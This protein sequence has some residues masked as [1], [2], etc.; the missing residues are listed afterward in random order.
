VTLLLPIHKPLS[1]LLVVLSGALL[2]AAAQAQPAAVPTT[3]PT[4]DGIRL[5]W[6]GVYKLGCW[7]PLEVEISGGSEPIVGQVEVTVPDSDGVPTTVSTLDHRPVGVDPGYTSVAR[8]FVRIGQSKSSI[9][10]RFVSEGQVLCERTFRSGL[11]EASGV[12]RGGIAATGQVWLLYGPQLGL[13]EIAQAASTGGALT[14]TRVAR[15]ERAADLPTRWF[16]YEG[17]ETVLLTTSN[18]ALYRPLTQ[19]SEPIKA[20]LRWVELGGRLVVFC[21]SEAPELLTS[22]GPLAPLVPGHFDGEMLPL[23]KSLPLETYSGA[24]QSIRGRLNVRV[25]RLIDVQGEVL[26]KAGSENAELPLVVRA[27]RGLGELIFVGLDFD[28]PPWNSWPG[29]TSFFRKL[30]DL[31]VGDAVD[32]QQS[33]SGMLA[34]QNEDLSSH[35]RS[36]LDERFS[37]VQPISFAL[38]ALL[39]VAYIGLIGPGDFFFVKRV[40]KRMELTWVT[41]P[42]IVAA[43]AG[44]AYAYAQS[45]KGDQLRVNQVE[46]VDVDTQGGLVRGTVW[47]HFFTPRVEQ[48]NLTLAPQFPGQQLVEDSRCL[49]SWLGLPGFALGGMQ[50]FATEA[51]DWETGYRFGKSLDAILQLPVQ[52]WSTKTITAR[53]T[54]DLDNLPLEADLQR[55][56]NG[57]L[58]GEIRADLGIGLEDCILLYGRWAYGLGDVADQQA[59]TINDTLQPRIIKTLLTSP[60]AG[61]E[62]PKRVADDGTVPFDADSFDVARIVKVMMFYEAVHGYRYTNMLNRYQQHTDLS[63]TLKNGRAVL[64]ARVPADGSQWLQGERP[65]GGDGDR[66]WLYYRFVIPVKQGE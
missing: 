38:V 35:L 20:L 32:D 29:R 31:P 50:T 61:D 24:E 18:P 51:T 41:F 36:A 22:E 53:W 6:D 63:Q 9:R 57:L 7:T 44:G 28:R 34:A 25:P 19:N 46:I 43:V 52:V 16:G 65:L 15:S 45:K 27:P 5:G 21:G 26:A 4:I 60:T 3:M 30:L 10:V 56:S 48:M 54:A 37:G 2:G 59:L 62:T 8:L 13:G 55:T 17:V 14:A 1:I 42:L 49:T 58:A 64:L 11:E 23:R 33:S 39:V 47:T 40:L 66:H 12:V